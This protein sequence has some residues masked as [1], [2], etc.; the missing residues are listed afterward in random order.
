MAQREDDN[1]PGVNQYHKPEASHDGP[2]AG[3]YQYQPVTGVYTRHLEVLT[4][5]VQGLITHSCIPTRWLSGAYLPAGIWR[6]EFAH[7][8]LK[9]HKNSECEVVWTDEKFSN[10]HFWNSIETH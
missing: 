9:I 10:I 3:L 5:Q 6:H 7:F 1:K 4:T 8:K 2:A